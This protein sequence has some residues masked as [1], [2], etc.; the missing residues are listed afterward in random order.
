ML[1]C[2]R[3]LVPGSEW[4]E[5]LLRFAFWS[6]NLGL[7]GMCVLSLLP[8]GLLQTWASVDKGYW[9]ARSSEFLQTDWM[10]TLR[11]LRVLGDTVFFTG[12]VAFIAFVVGL[13]T[14][15]AFQRK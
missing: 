9:Y 12:A 13:Y 4:K 7:F 14:G 11:W 1:L 15:G 2:L 6:M 3:L 5:G 10:E 8:V